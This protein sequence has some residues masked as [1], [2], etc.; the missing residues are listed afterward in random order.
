LTERGENTMTI[1]NRLNRANA[2]SSQSIYTHTL[3]S[4]QEMAPTRA[5]RRASTLHK[6]VCLAKRR[7]AGLANKF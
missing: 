5:I 7:G 3:I 6:P 1:E 4:S 2:A